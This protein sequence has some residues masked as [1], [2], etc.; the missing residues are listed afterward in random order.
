M[1]MKFDELKE[2]LTDLNISQA[3]F[4]RLA[5]LNKNSITKYKN[6][7]INISKPVARIAMLLRDRPELTEV[8]KGYE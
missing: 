8:L 3:E 7:V 2:I 1:C 4:A 6:G 5:G